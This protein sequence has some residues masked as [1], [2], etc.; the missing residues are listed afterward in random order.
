MSQLNRAYF[1]ISNTPG[2]AGDLT[3]SSAVAGPYRTLAAAHDGVAFDVAIVDGNAWEVRTDCTYTHAGTTL[4]RGTL[5][6]SSTGSAI[7]LTSS[8]VVMIVHTAGRIEDVYTAGSTDVALADGGTGSSLTDP[9]ADRILFWDD[10]AGAV[11]WL[12]VGSGLSVAGTTISTTAV[13]GERIATGTTDTIT[14]AD[15]NYTVIYTNT[16]A[17][18]V[19]IPEAAN[20]TACVL[21]WLAGAG[22]ITLDPTGTVELNG[23]TASIVLSAAS[24]MVA[25]TPTGT[26]TW[27]VVGSIGDL[28]IADVTDITASAAEINV[29]DGMTASTAELNVLDG[30][31]GTLTA[32]ELGYVDGVTSA[33]QTQLNAKAS[34][35]QGWGISATI[36]GTVTDQDIVL[37]MKVPAALNNAT[38]TETV[39]DCTSGTA[40]ATFK[41]NTTAL[42]GTANSV[43]STEQSQAHASANTLATGDDIVV[44]ISSASSLTSPRFSLSGSRTLS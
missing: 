40:T 39:T 23:S 38:I 18:T 20:G 21:Q 28:V 4:G 44:T 43:S 11:T 3:V 6:D 36:I 8:A 2:A 34:T 9:N 27:N 22:T 10:S 17:I 26:N 37:Y 24:G 32:T 12:T 31:P 15:E 33:I 30:I 19:T 16:G 42:G 1:T 14:T 29:L 41:I 13:G 5:E 25:L 35:T 7:T